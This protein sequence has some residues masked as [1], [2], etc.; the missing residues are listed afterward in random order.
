MSV[1]KSILLVPTSLEIHGRD[2]VSICS[3]KMEIENDILLN[4]GIVGRRSIKPL[5]LLWRLI[6]RS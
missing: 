6:D 2:A 4:R 1:S 5:E 3:H